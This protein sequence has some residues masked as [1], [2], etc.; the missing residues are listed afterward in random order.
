LNLSSVQDPRA[1]KD[2]VSDLDIDRNGLAALVA[3]AR[4]DGDDLAF[5]QLSLA[6]SA[7]MIPPTALSS[8]SMRHT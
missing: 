6:V 5:L 1:E 2:L 7:T 4:I 8:A 3:N